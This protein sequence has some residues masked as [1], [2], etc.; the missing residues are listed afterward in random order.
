MKFLK[1]M[2]CAVIIVGFLILTAVGGLYVAK[3]MGLVFWGIYCL[4]C[5]VLGYGVSKTTYHIL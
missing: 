1:V 2:L 5:A 3:T 4:I